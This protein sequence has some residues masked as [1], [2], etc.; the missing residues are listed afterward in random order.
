MLF[1][2]KCVRRILGWGEYIR[3]EQ[4]ERF[5]IDIRERFLKPLIGESCYNELCEAYTSDTLT[6]L[7]AAWVKKLQYYAAHLIDYFYTVDYLFASGIGNVIEISDNS[8]TPDPSVRQKRADIVL[9][10]TEFYKDE[11]LKFMQENA[12]EIT[13]IEINPCKSDDKSKKISSFVTSWK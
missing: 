8:S 7:Q 5:A 9:Q 4:F 2:E 13:C 10:R 3:F 1:D 12:I 6:D 11:V